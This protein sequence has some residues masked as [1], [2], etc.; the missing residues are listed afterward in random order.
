MKNSITETPK[1]A[2]FDIGEIYD[3]L[4]SSNRRYESFI[5]VP[6]LKTGMYIL[7]AGGEDNQNPHELDEVYYIVSG[8]G[9]F[10]SEGQKLDVK[11]GTILYVKAK[12]SHRFE[13]IEQELKIIIFFSE[14]KSK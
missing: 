6:A 2:S 12:T 4:K 1:W 13:D 9:K 10:V 8:R 14:A 7:P 11:P 3:R 5:D